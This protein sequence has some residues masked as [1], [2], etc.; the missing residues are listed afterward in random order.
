MDSAC[1]RGPRWRP[2]R[3]C[4]A[5]VL[6]I[7]RR[8]GPR[9]VWAKT[10]PLGPA[11]AL[12]GREKAHSGVKTLH[13]KHVS[14]R[15]ICLAKLPLQ[16]AGLEAWSQLEPCCRK[17]STPGMV[18]AGCSGPRR[19]WRLAALSSSVM[20]WGSRVTWLRGK[21]GIH[22]AKNIMWI[23]VGHTMLVPLFTTHTE[24]SRNAGCTNLSPDAL[25]LPLALVP[26]LGTDNPQT[27]V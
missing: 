1:D 24:G 5:S 15:K 13:S 8:F 3:S 19:S 27:A 4:W 23:Y 9:P 10:V 21:D 25:G 16:L 20:P 11:K 26:I 7:L 17:G 6:V 2:C 18:W 14:R 22:L 12:Y